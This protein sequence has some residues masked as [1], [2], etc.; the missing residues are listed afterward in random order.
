MSCEGPFQYISNEFPLLPVAKTIYAKYPISKERE[1]VKRR[2]AKQC[3]LEFK[4]NDGIDYE[5]H[6]MHGNFE[7][8]DQQLINA[9]MRPSL[10]GKFSYV[11]PIIKFDGK[12]PF[13]GE[14]DDFIDLTSDSSSVESNNWCDR[15]WGS[16]PN[17]YDSDQ[18]FD[19]MI[20]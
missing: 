19:K 20:E 13:N 4:A 7:A 2:L 14:K 11:N 10:Y 17:D 9:V 18:S 6:L 8:N 1:S 12:N 5:R 15:S 3:K 16:I